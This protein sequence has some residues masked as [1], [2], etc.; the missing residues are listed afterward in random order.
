MRKLSSIREFMYVLALVL[1]LLFTLAVYAPQADSAEP[2]T[3]PH[4]DLDTLLNRLPPTFLPG[5]VLYDAE[6][7]FVRAELGSLRF[8]SCRDA[9]DDTR[10]AVQK[11]MLDAPEGA[12]A[13]GICLPLHTYNVGDL[14]PA[15]P[16]SPA[17]PEPATVL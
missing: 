7:K 6:G 14:V 3:P 1:F 15:A 12:R 5:V 13:I 17:P 9:L 2:A 10:S 4:T 8:F 16:T 11:A